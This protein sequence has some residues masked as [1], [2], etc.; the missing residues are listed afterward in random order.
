LKKQQNLVNTGINS[1]KPFIT[2]YGRI[3]LKNSTTLVVT[4]NDTGLYVSFNII[5]I[6]FLTISILSLVRLSFLK[7]SE[8]EITRS[9][10]AQSILNASSA[11]YYFL[12]GFISLL[13]LMLS[14]KLLIWGQENKQKYFKY[15]SGLLFLVS[16]FLLVSLTNTHILSQ[17]IFTLIRKFPVGFFYSILILVSSL[18]LY[19]GISFWKSPYP[20]YRER[21]ITFSLT[22]STL[23]QKIIRYP[24]PFIIYKNRKLNY[25]SSWV[26]AKY[27]YPLSDIISIHKYTSEKSD[28]FTYFVMLLFS[29]TNTY[30]PTIESRTVKENNQILNIISSFLSLPCGKDLNIKNLGFSNPLFNA[31][32]GRIL[33]P[34]LVNNHVNNILA[35]HSQK[36]SVSATMMMSENNKRLAINPNDPEACLMLGLAFMGI[37]QFEAAIKK[38]QQSKIL[39]EKLGEKRQSVKV[40][41]YLYRLQT[42]MIPNS[43]NNEI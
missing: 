25:D 4:E 14:L 7:M 6:V 16:T 26:E 30:F 8:M 19:L 18:F 36:I 2:S 39:Y 28:E 42:Y 3:E 10:L 29:K 9:Q 38:L 23:I 15:L 31:T 43:I 12:G 24:I 21:I 40:A 11:S 1:M 17:G 13:I 5:G 34:N 37:N 35:S 20:Y 22:K 33:D 32:F 41:D 27:E